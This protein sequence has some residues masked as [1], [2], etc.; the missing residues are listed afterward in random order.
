MDCDG[1]PQ[2]SDK[3]CDKVLGNYEKITGEPMPPCS[4]EGP[5]P[6][7]G[8]TDPMGDDTTLPGGSN[9]K[10]PTDPTNPTGPLDPGVVF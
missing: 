2:A 1:E 9:P 4:V 5:A 6:V 7:D 10:D 8:N 3:A